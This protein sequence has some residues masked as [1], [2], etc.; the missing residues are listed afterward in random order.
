MAVEN[1]H[2][3]A[4]VPSLIATKENEE[5]EKEEE[6]EMANSPL[7]KM[8]IKEETVEANTAGYLQSIRSAADAIKVKRS[9]TIQQRG[10][11]F[12]FPSIS[13]LIK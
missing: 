10:R 4:K 5:E 8:I 2:L 13:P 11:F 1:L 6:E 12:L 9:L 3:L 7:W